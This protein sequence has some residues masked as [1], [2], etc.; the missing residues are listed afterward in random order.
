[1]GWHPIWYS[2]GW[3]PGR[4]TM[5]IWN[6]ESVGNLRSYSQ[7]LYDMQYNG[8]N[9]E[10]KAKAREQ[11]DAMT[12]WMNMDWADVG[13]QDIT[14]RTGILNGWVDGVK[15]T[16]ADYATSI[17]GYLSSFA[18]YGS[19]ALDYIK[20]IA[21]VND[22]I[23]GWTKPSNFGKCFL[24]YSEPGFLSYEVDYRWLFLQANFN[25]LNIPYAYL[26]FYKPTEDKYFVK[27]KYLSNVS[28][29]IGK[30]YGLN[31]YVHAQTLDTKTG[32]VSM[33]DSSVSTNSGSYLTAA[34]VKSIPFPVF[35]NEAAA[36]AFVA[37]R[38]MENLLNQEAFGMPVISVTR[39]HKQ[40][41]QRYG[42]YGYYLQ[43]GGFALQ[44]MDELSDAMGRIE[45]TGSRS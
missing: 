4:V 12:D 5:I 26:E 28:P 10:I 22:S 19:D 40:W 20:E 41:N 18:S 33:H 15:G 7:W 31:V 21:S 27:F 45:G 16:T 38:T 13:G 24:T 32:K 25:E 35:S 34:Q 39:M 23:E 29:T 14:L 44:L 8:E 3:A 6:K 37:N 36:N 2:L 43:T 17:K 42:P 30:A 9:A 1:M 11:I